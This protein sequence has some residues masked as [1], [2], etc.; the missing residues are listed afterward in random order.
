MKVRFCEIKTLLRKH[1]RRKVFKSKL[2]PIL[3]L[4]MSSS[5][6]YSG[7]TL[8]EAFGLGP[9]GLEG[10]QQI[11]AFLFLVGLAQISQGCIEVREKGGAT[12]D[13]AHAKNMPE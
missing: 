4:E 7:A 3:S 13:F 8:N 11:S 2:K 9:S 1:F 10:L 5:M 12:L 6:F